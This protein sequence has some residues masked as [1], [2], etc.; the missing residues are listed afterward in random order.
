M[1]RHLFGLAIV[2]ALACALGNVAN[3]QMLVAPGTA[4]GYGVAV[5]NAPWMGGTYSPYYGNTAY[6]LG[7]GTGSNYVVPGTA[8]Y[9]SGYSGFAA[10]GTNFYSSGNLGYPVAGTNFY[11]PVAG[12]PGTVFT[13][14]RAVPYYQAYGY[15]VYPVRP[16]AWRR[17][18][19]RGW[20][21]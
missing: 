8:I 6:M 14:Y 5:G 21:W 15:S 2:G 20:F 16:G 7:I 13:N 10:P 1:R 9:S 18:W 19:R 11:A 17:A 12:A 4:G 3:A